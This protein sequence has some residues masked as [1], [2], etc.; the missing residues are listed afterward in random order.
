MLA[1]SGGRGHLEEHEDTG[2]VGSI[3]VDDGHG[4]HAVVLGLPV[5]ANDWRGHENKMEEEGDG[6]LARMGAKKRGGTLD[7]LASVTVTGAPVAVS[8]TPPAASVTW[9]QHASTHGPSAYTPRQERG[10]APQRFGK[11]APAQGPAV[12][13]GQ[14]EGEGEKKGEKEDNRGVHCSSGTRT[15]VSSC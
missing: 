2:R 14:R 7:I 1:R 8:V 10:S 9:C 6:E 12:R 5:S 3:Q 11:C 15:W 4:I 13:R